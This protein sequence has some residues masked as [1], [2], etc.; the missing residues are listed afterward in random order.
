[1]SGP[2]PTTLRG[3]AR[4]GLRGAPGVSGRAVSAG[5]R[6]VSRAAGAKSGE[7]APSASEHRDAPAVGP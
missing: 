7:G 5:R 4:W 1:M 2:W 3:V 6:S